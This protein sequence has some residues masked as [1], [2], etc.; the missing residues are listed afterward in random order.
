[1]EIFA[2]NSIAPDRNGT[3]EN[4]DDSLAFPE[5]LDQ[6]TRT[7]FLSQDAYSLHKGTGQTDPSVW[8]DQEKFLFDNGIITNHVKWYDAMSNGFTPKGKDVP[9]FTAPQDC[10]QAPPA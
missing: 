2:D 7:S 4:P 5:D 8:K 6:S 3:Y 9:T 10:V 1:V